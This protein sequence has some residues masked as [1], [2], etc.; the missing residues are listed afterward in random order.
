MR[1][2]HVSLP[3]DQSDGIYH[4]IGIYIAEF[5]G[6]I[7]ILRHGI[8]AMIL[9]ESQRLERSRVDAVFEKMTADPIRTAFFSMS[10]D[11]SELDVEDCKLRDI[12]NKTVQRLTERRNEIAHADWHIG[13]MDAHTR[14]MIEPTATKI[15]ASVKQGVSVKMVY[16]FKK[17]DNLVR[18]V[19]IAQR[20]AVHFTEVC[21]C[22]ARGDLS[23]KLT[24][25]LMVESSEDY[26]KYLMLKPGVS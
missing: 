13:W 9:D 22:R 3:W 5:S 2:L 25:L 14:E 17:L 7:A 26:G 8:I 23:R 1:R 11:L 19:L 16:D 18:E 20:V 15:Y 12:F 21:I 10:A 24:D 4:M 6:I